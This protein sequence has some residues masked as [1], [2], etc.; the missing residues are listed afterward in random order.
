M[1]TFDNIKV[2]DKVIYIS[3]W[4]N[5]AIAT[6]TRVTP[7]DNFATDKTDKT[8]WDKYGHVRGTDQW[9]TS[10]VVEYSEE[11]AK[12]I[13]EQSII[14]KAVCMMRKRSKSN[15]TVDQAKAIIDILEDK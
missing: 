10:R 15:L 6:V 8:L 14:A 9:Y 7:A 12:K 2:G 1:A 11:Y 5:N 3:D 13:I 4:G